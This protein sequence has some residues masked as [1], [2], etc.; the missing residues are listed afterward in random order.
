MVFLLL[1]Q[2]YNEATRLLGNLQH[3]IDALSSGIE[4]DTP[5]NAVDSYP[6]F[7]GPFESALTYTEPNNV[8]FDAGTFE[9][10]ASAPIGFRLV[11][12]LEEL[13]ALIVIR[14]SFEDWGTYISNG[15]VMQNSSEKKL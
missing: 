2:L 10:W 6:G 11:K 15:I 4:G 12:S 9:M 14:I 3:T 7:S 13:M 1:F 8:F 5:T